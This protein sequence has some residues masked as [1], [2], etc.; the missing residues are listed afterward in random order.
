MPIPIHPTGWPALWTRMATGFKRRAE[1]DFGARAELTAPQPACGEAAS[2]FDAALLE[3]AWGA[4]VSPG[5]IRHG[6]NLHRADVAQA[7]GHSAVTVGD[8]VDRVTATE[9]QLEALVTEPLPPPPAP[10]VL[11]SVADILPFSKGAA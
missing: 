4:S 10:K 8:L 11:R 5:L 2:D 1:P 9:Q 3:A 6:F 7:R